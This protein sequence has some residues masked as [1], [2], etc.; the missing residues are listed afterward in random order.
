MIDCRSRRILLAACLASLLGLGLGPGA[1]GQTE[2]PADGSPEPDVAAAPAPPTPEDSSPEFKELLE[3]LQRVER[4]L[5]RL[6]A[7]RPQVP[8]D[9]AAQRL[10]AVLETPHLG[11]SYYG[12]ANG[13]RYFAARLVF[14][15]LTPEAAIIGRDD[16]TLTADGNELKMGELPDVLR[17]QS[18]QI[19]NQHIALRNIAPAKEVRVPSGGTGSTWVLFTG[20]PGGNQIPKMTVNFRWGD[21]RQSLDVNEFSLGGL[22]LAVERIGPRKSLGLVTISGTLDTINLG[23][24]FEELENLTKDNVARAVIAWSD[25]AGPVD[26]RLM[27][28]LQ[29]VAVQAGRGEVRNPMYP[30]LP[31]GIRELHLAGIPNQR[32][33]GGKATVGGTVRIHETAAEAVSAALQSAFEVLPRDELLEEIQNGHA[34][35]RAAAL[36]AGG[37]RLSSDK[38]PLILQYAD[39][40][41]PQ[42]Q[43]AALYVL[44]HF[45][46]PEAIEKLVHYAR[47]NVEPLSNEAIESLAGSRYGAAHEALLEI[48][49][50]EGP[51]SRKRIVTVLAKYP[52]PVWSETIYQ[53]VKDSQAGLNVEALRALVKV[54]HPKLF[55]VL[56]DAL[57]TGDEALRNEALAVLVQRTDPESERLALDYALESLKTS[58][59]SGHILNLLNR[60]RDTRA[61][62]LLLKHLGETSNQ[63]IGLISTLGRIGDERVAEA[64][65]KLYPTLPNG[66]K[67]AVLSALQDLR[68]PDFR[69][70]AGEALH[71]ND[72]TLIRAACQG[73]Q[74]DAGPEALKLLADALKKSSNNTTWSYVCN[75]L[76]NLGTP[77]AR[78]ALRE[79]R[80]SGEANKRNYANNALRN[81][82]QRSPAF[83]FVMQGQGF[84]REQK[85]KEAAEQ[86]TIA[87]Q[88][89]ADMP[90]AY[91]GRASARLELNEIEE[92]RQDFRK[93]YELDPYNSQAITGLGLAL[94]LEDKYDEAIKTVED[95][96][97]KFA[98]DGLFPY[99]SACVYARALERVQKAE[100]LPDR[101]KRAEEYRRKALEQLQEAVK[102]GFNDLKWMHKDPDLNSLHGLK[103]F[104]EIHKQGATEPAS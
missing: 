69:K 2:A 85:W 75:T 44:R 29:Q 46:A 34:Y 39:D 100:N 68:S 104:D 101:E 78:Q 64:F 79:A 89:D 28:W 7:R 5:E 26:N 66:D 14:V 36:A 67:A 55:E 71:S 48:L 84:F 61:I 52:R 82:L 18:F 98:N 4:E 49:E 8:A 102:K 11:A 70:L 73:L 47:K 16:I 65:V 40:N 1:W 12:R 17:H 92:A 53:F 9:K 83:Q 33:S 76:A 19:G 13:L 81:I 37:G 90:D 41:D 10:V 27:S 59:P 32:R 80:E 87:I 72:G 74:A 45:G 22:G 94:V 54:G 86:Y 43:R 51:E 96:R 21:Q 50:N 93:A 6:K 63:R 25:S 77:E 99:N 62:P 20:L 103:E 42:M 3:R 88:M 95:A 38:L 23:S 31:A 58:P 30:P 35:T 97:E 15:N 24:L 60:T 56:R 57:E 91:S